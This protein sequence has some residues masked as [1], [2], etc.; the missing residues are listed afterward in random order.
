ML[1]ITLCLVLFSSTS[2]I[3]ADD[4]ITD[5]NLGKSRPKRAADQ[6]AN[7]QQ[8]VSSM[9]KLRIVTIK[10]P[11]YVYETED[12]NIKGNARYYGFIPDL[13][14]ELANRI[15][16]T[17]EFYDLITYGYQDENGNW[18]GAIGELLKHEK[19]SS[20]GAHFAA[21]A[22]TI[23]SRRSEVVDFIQPFAHVGISVIIQK[24]HRK[25]MAANQTLEEYFNL[26][27]DIFKPLS[28]EVWIT[29][30]VLAIVVWLFNWLMNRYNPYEYG[31]RQKR[32]LATEEESELFSLTG[33]LWY[34]FSLMQW[35][36]YDRTPRC[37]ASKLLGCIWMGFVTVT[38]VTYIGSFVNYMFWSS[39][40]HGP[41]NPL[42]PP[43][44]SLRDLVNHAEGYTY[45]TIKGGATYQYLT[46]VARGDEFTQIKRYF[47]QAFGQSQLVSTLEEGLQKVRSEKYAL[48]VETPVAKYY[49][50][51]HPCDLMLTNI[52]VDMRSYGLALPKTSPLREFIHQEIIEL[53]E[54][55]YLETLQDRWFSD[56][57]CWNVTFV[58]NT[59]SRMA[60]L[61]IDQ[62]QRVTL[63]IFWSPLV[64][65]II[66]V[67]LSIGVAIAEMLW[68]KYRGR[69]ESSNRQRGVQLTNE[70]DGHI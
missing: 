35:Q 14:F 69:Y 29:I 47:G 13:I 1:M 28:A 65:M 46:Q 57:E 20:E 3:N 12:D 30:T 21:T 52:E 23:T 6:P 56:Q 19:N 68:Y 36:G 53:T 61:Y 33:S 22:M 7:L 63:S 24:P 4:E 58:E 40:V 18:T 9:G 62:P 59:V 15:G 8:I 50:N 49:V 38:L 41:K 16:F 45:G 67:V 34:T 43:I 39:M 10:Y 42:V 26:N 48:F 60:S 64:V 27:F 31:E 55:G 25:N 37:L 54:L 51:K 5:V 70:D 44:Q 32:N 11:P 17:Y 66:G 2:L